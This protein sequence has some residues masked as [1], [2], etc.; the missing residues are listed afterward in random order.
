[1]NPASTMNTQN[2]TH[3][4][5]NLPLQPNTSKGGK[6]KNSQNIQTKA[7]PQPSTS[8]VG[9]NLTSAFQFRNLG[10]GRPHVQCSPCGRYDHFRKDCHQDNFCTRCRTRSHATHMCRALL[11]TDSNNICVYCGST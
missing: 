4:S 3:T 8:N 2:G 9:T 10:T 11:N 7:Q 5:R 1:M 6:E